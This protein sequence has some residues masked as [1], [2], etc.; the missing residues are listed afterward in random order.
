MFS[1]AKA[2]NL[3]PHCPYNLKINL[4]EN[5]QPPIGRM[6]LLLEHELE[7]L[8]MFLDKN[9]QTN[10]IR[11]FC[12]AHGAP[13]LFIK[14]KD[15]SLR[16]CVNYRGLNKISKKDQ[17]PLLLIT[18]LLDAPGKAKI[19]TKIDLCHTYH[20]IQIWEGDKWKTTF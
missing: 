7:A 4:E 11:P 16:L 10:S 2:G 18:D 12:S 6:Y 20:L 8:Q 13:I 1:K 17:Y 15:G 14:R 9:L 19:Y 3:V 5:A